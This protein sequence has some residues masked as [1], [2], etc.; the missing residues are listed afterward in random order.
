MSKKL[1]T[2]GRVYLK[3][4]EMIE[5]IAAIIVANYTHAQDCLARGE[6]P[7]DASYTVP[8]IWGSPGIGKT[9]VVYKA[10]EVACAQL[11][12]LFPDI[13]QDMP[14]IVEPIAD[15]SPEEIT[16]YPR[17]DSEETF[18][19][20]MPRKWY[21]HHGK[22]IVA[23]FDEVAQG[24]VEQQNVARGAMLGQTVGELTF[25]PGSTVIAAS[26]LMEDRAGTHVMPTHVRDVLCHLYM[27]PDH[28][29]WALWAAEKGMAFEISSFIMTHGAQFLHDLSTDSTA[30]ACPSPRSWE[31]ADRIYK[32]PAPPNLSSKPNDWEALKKAMISGTVGAAACGALYTH[33][34]LGSKMPDIE[35]ILNGTWSGRFTEED[36]GVMYMT[37]CALS[38][39]ADPPRFGN[40]VVFLKKMK[41]KEFGSFC[42]NMLIR[43]E[44]KWRRERAIQAWLIENESELIL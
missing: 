15:K 23:F 18:R 6:R 39:L 12:K 37:M 30:L 7:S 44:N 28:K 17:P 33:I 16:G 34:K 10:G 41:H 38:G 2:T 5:I 27:R 22:P 26:N 36:T 3:P 32:M 31:K 21:E 35:S 42:I 25:C 24:N 8:I 29:E 4:S 11:R 14:V 9:R 40:L 13:F 43:R 1:D 19:R 20:L